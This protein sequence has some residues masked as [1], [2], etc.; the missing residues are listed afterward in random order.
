MVRLPTPSGR[1]ERVCV[2]LHERAFEGDPQNDAIG[3]DSFKTGQWARL[4]Y[5]SVSQ[6]NCRKC[7]SMEAS[8]AWSTVHRLPEILYFLH[9]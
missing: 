8:I 4:S 6:A 2:A 7:Y 9:K 1:A 5:S 3:R